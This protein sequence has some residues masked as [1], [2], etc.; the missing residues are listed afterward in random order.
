MLCIDKWL[1]VTC[2][3]QPCNA[4]NVIC[5]LR[6]LPREMNHLPG[7]TRGINTRGWNS[8]MFES[9]IEPRKDIH[10]YHH[11]L[12]GLC[13]FDHLIF[14]AESVRV[15]SYVCRV[16]L[17]PSKSVMSD[18]EHT[19]RYT[20]YPLMWCFAVGIISITIIS[21]MIAASFSHC[22]LSNYILDIV[23]ISLKMPRYAHIFLIRV[24]LMSAFP[25]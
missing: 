11:Y 23:I 22:G 4:Y 6:Y 10:L 14:S 16:I 15:S 9:E 7:V 24:I 1:Q 2:Y 18:L 19:L 20:W 25:Y 17:V 12:G 21:F 5:L 13:W 3:T 8:N